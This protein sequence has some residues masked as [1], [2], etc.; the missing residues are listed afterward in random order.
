MGG[1]VLTLSSMV[2]EEMK[3]E[4]VVSG[5][6]ESVLWLNAAVYRPAAVFKSTTST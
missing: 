5:V 6:L 3:E 1:A 4:P 2:G